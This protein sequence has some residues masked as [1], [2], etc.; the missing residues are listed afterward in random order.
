MQWAAILNRGGRPAMQVGEEVLFACRHT[1]RGDA[2]LVLARLAKGA[3]QDQRPPFGPG[4][5]L[6]STWDGQP[7][8]AVLVPYAFARPIPPELKD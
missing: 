5:Y 3:S 6:Q 1:T 7:V 4:L 2:C 8:P